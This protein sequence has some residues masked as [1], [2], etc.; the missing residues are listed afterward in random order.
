MRQP[1][2]AGVLEA[3]VGHWGAIFISLGL[4][5]SVLGAYLA[6][7]LIAAEVLFVGAKNGDMPKIFATENKQQVPAAALWVTN[8][9]VQLYRHQHLLVAG[10]LRADAESDQRDV[11]D[12][13]SVRGG[14]R[15]R[16]SRAARDLRP[17]PEERQPRS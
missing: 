12:P 11:A 16:R 15:R 3:V 17:R 7:S 13:L 4:L 5:V 6:W 14:L 9:V 8:I 2:M 1:S 10:R